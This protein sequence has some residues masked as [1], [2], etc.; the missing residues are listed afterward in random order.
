[1]SERMLD[2]SE[3]T[4]SRELL[5]ARA[6]R[7]MT[8]TLGII[9]LVLAVGVGWCIFGKI[10]IVV[11]A[12]G[13]VRSNESAV[14]IINR[15]AGSVEKID[16]QPGQ[17]VKKGQVLYEMNQEEWHSSYN[18]LTEQ[19]RL[20]REQSSQ[21]VALKEQLRTGTTDTL[22]DDLQIEEL[23]SGSNPEVDKLKL[24]LLNVRSKRKQND[25][26]VDQLDKLKQSALEGVNRLSRDD[27][28]YYRYENYRQRTDQLKLQ[29]TALTYA[30]KLA[31]REGDEVQI[32]E[33]Q[34][35]LD[36]AKLAVHSA[37]S[38][39]QYSVMSE[40][41]SARQA[42]SEYRD[43]ESELLIQLTD[44]I[45]ATKKEVKD[46]EYNNL[47]MSQE[48]DN[49][50]VKAPISGT[51]SVVTEFGQGEF[52]QA[53]THILTIVPENGSEMIMQIAVANRD[54]ARIQ[55]GMPVKYRIN[56]LPS[57]EYGVL[58]GR[59]ASMNPDATIDSA[60]GMGYYVVQGE[61]NGLTL[62]NAK[63]ESATIKVGMAAETSIVTERKNI[64]IWLLEKLDFI[65]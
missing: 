23:L 40:L 3:L 27:E 53:G 61:I 1:M 7:T 42:Q 12:P 16:F 21:L 41:L 57:S 45:E 33:A 15:V 37:E 28:M 52:V 14:K 51:V 63:G 59:V 8:W 17:H 49:R 39:F 43:K 58:R 20:K 2:W 24:S 44:T 4:D 18:R 65:S 56:A 55:N 13:V 11:K 46:L 50:V 38:D 35:N 64:G 6:P 34:R 26:L 29:V 25:Q 48:Q 32:E 47:K 5:E 9:L 60:T 62:T 36:N 30:M 22:T 10:D 19:L 31:L 54:I